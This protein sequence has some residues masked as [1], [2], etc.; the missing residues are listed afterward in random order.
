MTEAAT[1]KKERPNI[2]QAVDLM[3]DEEEAILPEE[4]GVEEPDWRE[5]LIDT[6]FD[7]SGIRQRKLFTFMETF[8][9]WRLG[10]WEPPKQKDTPSETVKAKRRELARITREARG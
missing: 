9:L 2:N 5:Y 4:V 1:K 3:V 7:S 8:I 10:M 6:R